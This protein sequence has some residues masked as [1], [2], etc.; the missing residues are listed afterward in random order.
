VRYRRGDGRERVS[1][2]AS[3]S[4]AIANREHRAMTGLLIAALLLA[5]KSLL[6]VQHEELS[7]EVEHIEQLC[8]ESDVYSLRLGAKT[9]YG[10]IDLRNLFSLISI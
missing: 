9:C 10:T 5:I 3:R 8:F 4:Q 1:N 7:S 2:G 6:A